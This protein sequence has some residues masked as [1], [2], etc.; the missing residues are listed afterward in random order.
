MDALDRIVVP[1][2]DLL[3]RVDSALLS[4]GAPAGHP[5]W[6]LLR[7]VGALPSDAVAAISALEP[8]PLRATAERLR[9]AADGYARP[10]ADI[11]QQE[12]WSGPAAEVFTAHWRDLSVFL[13]ASGELGLAGRLQ[14]TAAYYDEVADWMTESRLALAEA[15]ATVLGSAEA[16]RLPGPGQAASDPSWLSSAQ[17]GS[18]QS[19]LAEC[20]NVHSESTGSAAAIAARVL[21]VVAGAIDDGHDV[22]ERWAA[23]LGE[24]P[25]RMGAGFGAAGS[26]GTT[27]VE[28]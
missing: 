24:L 15:L 28:L 2:Q 14:A 7:R 21:G 26:G 13:S 23:R 6:P 22:R 17:W 10:H 9:E 3:E 5:V 20:G 25:F 18:P 8:A 16:V 19:G 1:A 12:Q 27:T 11:D 4:G